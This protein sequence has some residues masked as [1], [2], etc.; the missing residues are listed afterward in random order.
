MKLPKILLLSFLGVFS[1]VS[2]NA[3]TLSSEQQA[4]LNSLP[5]ALRAQAIEEL[6]KYNS[7]NQSENANRPIEQQ[8]VVTRDETVESDERIKESFEK[9]TGTSEDEEQF[10]E[11]KIEQE[12]KQF[13]YNLFAGTPTTFAPGT[14]D[15]PVPVDY[16]VGPGDQVRIQLFGKQSASYDLYVSREGILQ[17]PELGP[18]SVVGQTF[19]ELKQNIARRVSEQMIGMDVFI[20]LGELRSIRVFL[21]GDV[22]H[23]GAYTVSSLSTITNAL[24]VSGGIRSIGSLRNIELKREGEVIAILD[25]YDLLLRG[26]IS[27]DLPLQPGD[28]IFVPPVG[29]LTGVAGEVRRPAIYELKNEDSIDQ[30]IEL[31]GGLTS[32]AYPSLSQIERI[33][34][35]GLKTLLDVDLTKSGSG[36][37]PIKDGDT[38]RIYSALDRVDNYVRVEGMVERPGDYQWHEGI[39]ISDIISHIEQLQNDADL[40]YALVVSKNPI[41]GRWSTRSFSFEKYFLGQDSRHNLELRP[42]DRIIVFDDTNVERENI[43]QVI[44]RLK[45]QGTSAEPQK[46][47]SI[48]GSVRHPGEYPLDQ[49][50]PISDLIRAGGGFTQDAYTLEAELLRFSDNGKTVRDSILL[51]IDLVSLESNPSLDIELKPF[52]LLTIKRIPEW[53]ENEQIE[54]S[55]EIRFPGVY[56]IERGETLSQVIER[57]GGLTSL[58]HPESAVFLRESLRVAE[59]ENILK[60]RERLRGEI[61]STSLQNDDVSSDS[62]STAE[63]LLEQLENTEAAGR[64]VINLPEI[65]MGMRDVTLKAGDKLKVPKEPQAVTIIGSVNYPTSHLYQNDLTRDDYISLSGGLM[66]NADKKQI[67]IVRA[68][69]RVETEKRSRFFPNGSISI[70]PGDTIV[71]PIDVDRMA[72]LK[73]WS[74][75]S[76]IFYQIA[77]GAAAINSF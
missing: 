49:Q 41:D 43:E 51:P 68:N 74:A 25:L 5:P 52:D 33:S 18:I 64:L 59:Q 16:V 21:L 30:V 31:A 60:L 50:M 1:A 12:L 65:L 7:A 75:T 32:L 20:T 24:F 2:S 70:Q 77:L 19:Q 6:R 66:R 61:A 56:T 42:N 48:S 62:I 17:V 13:G 38:V 54:L 45:A 9:S 37:T 29:K 23:P 39:R 22:K 8:E 4:K 76:Q 10:S 27:K 72:P 14:I 15:I 11:K 35:N 53:T 69:G 58:A 46:I 34:D 3:Q 71:V 57:A 47:V 28:V 63:S 67:Y 40:S 44:E 36:D 55:G 26:D 73:L